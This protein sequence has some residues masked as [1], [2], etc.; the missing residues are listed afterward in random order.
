VNCRNCKNN[1]LLSVIDLGISP[2]SNDYLNVNQ[3]TFA[4]KFYPLH[5]LRCPKCGLVQTRDFLNSDELFRNDYAYFSSISDTWVRHVSEFCSKIIAQRELNHKSFVLEIA[6]ND[7]YLLKNFTRENIPCLG[8]EP[9]KSTAKVA[10][11]NN[12]PTLEEFFTC[13]LAKA[14]VEDFGLSDL[15]IANNVLAH[16]PDIL[17]FIKGIE[18]CL[19]AN[20]VAIFEFPH[21]LTLIQKCAYDTI[22]HEHFSYLSL[23]ALENIFLKTKLIIFAV[24]ELPTHGGSLRV[25]VKHRVNEIDQIDPS[26]EVVKEREYCTLDDQGFE[27]FRQQVEISKINVCQVLYGYRKKGLM[28]A[29]YGAAAKG[30]T[31]L[32]YCGI[33][34]D[35]ISFIVDEASAKQ[36][37]FT[38]G[39]RIPI[40]SP[41]HLKEKRPDIIIIFP[42]NIAE[43]IYDR[44]KS[45]CPSAKV[46]S[47]QP[48]LVTHEY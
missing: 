44:I 38:P 25:F 41:E 33:G 7:G 31:M 21:L 37:K 15:I 28:I 26:V 6:S 16:V 14:I 23:T 34:S 47:F 43:E 39:M 13:K 2:P 9:T 18:L 30:N 22:Y 42:W 36:N 12:I 32:N 4:E 11:E 5:I 45:L 35:V 10:I 20:G 8:V 1:K 48:D 40:V 17:G 27:N 3:L 29:G 19:D 46:I 24:E